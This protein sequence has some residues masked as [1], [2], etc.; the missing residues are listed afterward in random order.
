MIGSTTPRSISDL[1][2]LARRRSPRI[3]WRHVPIEDNVHGPEAGI[4][5]TSLLKRNVVNDVSVH[6]SRYILS[7]SLEFLPKLFVD[8]LSLSET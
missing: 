4:Y 6:V 3:S 1:A 5:L 2:Q 8:F 7:A